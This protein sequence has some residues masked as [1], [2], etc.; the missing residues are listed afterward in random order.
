M[1][2]KPLFETADLDALVHLCETAHLDDPHLP[3]P[4]YYLYERAS[5]T[6]HSWYE[7]YALPV[8][9]DEARGLERVGTVAGG[10]AT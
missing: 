1:G 5:A 10:G 7:A 4:P 3:G 9:R 6:G 2:V 8:E